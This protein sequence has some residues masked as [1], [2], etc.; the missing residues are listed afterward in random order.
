MIIDDHED[1]ED[2]EF[3]DVDNASDTN[4]RDQ[5]NAIVHNRNFRF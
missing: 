5:I 3:T 1:E 4:G 2:G